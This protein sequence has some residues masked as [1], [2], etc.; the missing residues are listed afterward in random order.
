MLDI[1]MAFV[2]V[3]ATIANLASLRALP[4]KASDCDRY[5]YMSDVETVFFAHEHQD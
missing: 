3:P 4:L 1:V 2:S 5:V